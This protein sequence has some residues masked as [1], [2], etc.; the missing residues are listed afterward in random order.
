MRYCPLCEKEIADSDY[1]L[2]MAKH[3]ESDGDFWEDAE[4]I[5]A[6]VAALSILGGVLGGDD[7]SG[8]NDVSGGGGEFGGG[9]ASGEW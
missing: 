7:S 5:V 9:G 1:D 4:D 3:N 6:G 8:S 2:H